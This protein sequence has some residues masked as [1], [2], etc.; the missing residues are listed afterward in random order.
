M[1]A[2]RFHA[3]GDVDVLKLEDVPEP[4]PGPGEVLVRVRAA[5][6]NFADTRFRRGEYFVRPVFPQIPGM[7][8]AGEIVALGDGAQGAIGDRVMALA[9]GTYAE[10]VVCKPH[11]V[12]PIPAALGFEEAAALPAQG[13]TAHHLL[14]LSGRM[15]RGERVLVHAAAGGVGTLAVQL[16]K[17]RGASQIIATAGSEA[18]LDLARSLGA[19]VA[20]D[21]KDDQWPAKVK[22]ATGGAGVNVLLE[23]LGGTEA[24]KRNLSLLA[25]FGRMVVFGAASG[26]THGTIEPVMLM[27]KNQSIIGYYLTPLLR[28]RE[29]CAPPLAE[30]A[31]QTAEGKLKVII[32]A[33]FPLAEAAAAHTAMEARHTIGKIVLLP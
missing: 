23:M 25:P 12:Y 7:E 20:V 14:G 5:G 27:A 30:I 11:E 31:E 10:L 26:D 4:K 9:S 18:K 6:V 13:L 29:L 17:M 21:Y 28:H 2:I 8:C 3:I 1:K 16:A 24:L 22:S 19:D 32:G 33:R 15:A